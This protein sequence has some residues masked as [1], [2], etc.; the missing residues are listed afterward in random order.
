[1]LDYCSKLGESSLCGVI[2]FLSNLILSLSTS[3]PTYYPSLPLPSPLMHPSTVPQDHLMD[4]IY[5]CLLCFTYQEQ[6]TLKYYII[7]RKLLRKVLL[8]SSFL[9]YSYFFLVSLSPSPSPSS[10]SSL[11]FFKI[12]LSGAPF[13]FSMAA[14][15]YEG[16]E[17]WLGAKVFF[18]SF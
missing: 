17:D 9:F 3:S 16:V 6:N 14:H 18:S 15:S 4:P 13:L 7:S 8:S 1:M 12:I 2:S 10:L 5:A 11:S